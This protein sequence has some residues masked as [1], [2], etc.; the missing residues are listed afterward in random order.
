[1]RRRERRLRSMLRHEQQTVRMALAA[2]LHH[3]VGPKEKVELLQNAALRGQKRPPTGGSG[4]ASPPEPGPQRSLQILIAIACSMIIKKTKM[5]MKMT[6]N[7][8]ARKK[9]QKQKT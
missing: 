4:Q 8:N 7:E 6:K 2:A 3:S 9:S 5:K 1:M